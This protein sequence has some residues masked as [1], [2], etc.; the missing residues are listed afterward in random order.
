MTISL[1]V[2]FTDQ[3]QACLGTKILAIN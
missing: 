3:Q 1:V 2:E